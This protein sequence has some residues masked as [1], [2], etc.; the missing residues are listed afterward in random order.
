M[1]SL[2]EVLREFNNPL[3]QPWGIGPLLFK[4]VERRVRN[5]V[6]SAPYSIYQTFNDGVRWAEDEWSAL[7]SEVITEFLIGQNQL[8][9]VM[10]AETIGAFNYRLDQQI[11]RCLSARRPKTEIDNLFKTS[12]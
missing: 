3:Y 9:Y 6:S 12:L 8:E 4:E 5:I 1:S 2:P 10:R 11:K 7:S